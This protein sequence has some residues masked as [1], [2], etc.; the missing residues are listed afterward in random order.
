MS[1]KNYINFSHQ[2]PGKWV[3]W[4]KSKN[5]PG[6]CCWIL[7]IRDIE[8]VENVCL[9]KRTFQSYSDNQYLDDLIQKEPYTSDEDFKKFEMYNEG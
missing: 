1:Q 8:G 9:I 7:E 3:R 2:L 5:I 4:I 6:E